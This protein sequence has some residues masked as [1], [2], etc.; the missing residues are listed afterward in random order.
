MSKITLS[1]IKADVGGF[2]GHSS[3][4]PNLITKAI[5]ILDE[6]KNKGMLIDFH[7]SHCGDDLELIMS[8][9]LGDDSGEIHKMAWDLFVA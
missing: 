3:M 6:H 9:R 2:V 5:Q 1:V 8:H 4:H 7:V